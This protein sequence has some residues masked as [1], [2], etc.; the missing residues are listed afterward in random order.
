[1]PRYST[2]DPAITRSIPVQSVCARHTG[3]VLARSA[4][5]ATA[6]LDERAIVMIAIVDYGAGNLVSV[7]K[8]LDWLGE[9]VRSAAIHRRFAPPRRSCFPAWDICVNASTR[10]LWRA[11][12]NQGQD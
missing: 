6:A 3:G 9:T 8:A 1:M 12:R 7:K 10:G 11:V 5:E 2:G 4:N